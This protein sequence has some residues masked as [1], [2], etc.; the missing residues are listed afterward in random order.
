MDVA[1]D[2]RTRNDDDVQGTTYEAQNDDWPRCDGR[3]ERLRRRV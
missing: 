1:V 3:V 2:I